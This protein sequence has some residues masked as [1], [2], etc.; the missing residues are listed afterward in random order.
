VVVGDAAEVFE[1]HAAYIFK[2]IETGDFS[3]TLM[4]LCLIK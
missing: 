2:V 1:V 3:E 4:P